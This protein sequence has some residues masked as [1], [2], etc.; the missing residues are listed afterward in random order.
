MASFSPSSLLIEVVLLSNELAKVDLEGIVGLLFMDCEPW[1]AVET[2]LTPQL[3]T[4]KIAQISV[5]IAQ[6]S[7]GKKAIDVVHQG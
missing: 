6:H 1:E 4:M 5:L 3:R 7:T 2:F